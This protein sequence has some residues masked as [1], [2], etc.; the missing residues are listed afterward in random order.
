MYARI[1]YT[2]LKKYNIPKFIKHKAVP[3]GKFMAQNTY[4]KKEKV[5]NQ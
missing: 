1:K 2:Y 3:R 5:L 4:Q